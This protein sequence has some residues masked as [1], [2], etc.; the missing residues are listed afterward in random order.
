[1]VHCK[2]MVDGA[3]RRFS[4]P[5]GPTDVTG[6]PALTLDGLRAGLAAAFPTVDSAAVLSFVDGDGDACLLSTDGDLREALAVSPTL[7]RLRARPAPPPVSALSAAAMRIVN[8]GGG[9]GAAD[10]ARLRVHHSSQHPLLFLA[11]HW[12]SATTPAFAAA[13]DAVTAGPPTFARAKGGQR[14]FREVAKICRTFAAGYADADALAAAQDQA[15]TNCLVR[16]A[17]TLVKAGADVDRATVVVEAVEAAFMDDGVRAALCAE[18][19]GAKMARQKPARAAQQQ[20]GPAGGAVGGIAAPS[21]PSD[22][23]IPEAPEA[24]DAVTAL[25]APAAECDA[26]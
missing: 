25:P 19:L 23:P 11:K 24:R 4:L 8:G 6:S 5:D 22:A 21:S 18:I 9:G 26:T 15:L 1:M 17:T 12:P 2:M 13:L 14:A 10:V 20:A 7:L 16:V 3:L